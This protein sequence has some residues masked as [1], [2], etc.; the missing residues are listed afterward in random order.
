[1]VDGAGDSTGHSRFRAVRRSGC[2]APGEHRAVGRLQR[3]AFP[4]PGSGVRH[5]SCSEIG[6]SVRGASEQ[7]CTA[8]RPGRRGRRFTGRR[9]TRTHPPMFRKAERASHELTFEVA[10]REDR[11]QQKLSW[12]LRRRAH[13]KEGRMAGYVRYIDRTRDYYLSKGYDKPYQW[14][15]FEDVPS[16]PL[17]KPLSQSGG[18]QITTS[19]IGVRGMELDRDETA[20]VSMGGHYS[21]PSDLPVE[22]YYS[23]S[24][25]FDRH[26]T[27]LEDV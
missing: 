26:A 24:H 19:D 14:A 8:R 2:R 13:R 16:T 6:R 1:L 17:G 21:M 23:N 5:R 15:H 3:G 18:A 11:R 9:S 4:V 10:R 27:T 7:S 22:R 12:L 20:W 25:G